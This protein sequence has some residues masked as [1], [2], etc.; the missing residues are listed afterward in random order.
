M[1]E[2]SRRAAKPPRKGG[3]PNA[4]FVV[5]SAER[6]PEELNGLADELT[7]Q[8]P[9]GSLLRG[10]LG[11]DEQAARGIARL[12]KPGGR[13]LATF[14]VEARDGLD[15]PGLDGGDLARRWSRFG[16]VV[17]EFRSATSADLGAMSSSWA[18][19]LGAGR[20]RSAWRLELE[21][22][23]GHHR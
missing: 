12:L 14:S 16:L 1:A 23:Y 2:P 19:R 15:L 8:F 6:V 18:R 17:C 11:L 20:E 21:R 10:T 22:A 5:A 3:L 7:I 13:A 9:W 4:L